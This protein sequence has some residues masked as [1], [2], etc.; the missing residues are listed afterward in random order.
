MHVHWWLWNCTENVV[1]NM[2][3][4]ILEKKCYH[5]TGHK[6][7]LSKTKRSFWYKNLSE[8]SP[9]ILS[10]SQINRPHLIRPLPLPSP[11]PKKINDLPATSRLEISL[12]QGNLILCRGSF[13]GVG[14]RNYYRKIGYELEGPYMV[15]NLWS[16]S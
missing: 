1:E 10:S 6:L 8:L 7:K 15:K 14:T 3:V 2:R 5:N 4:D 11:P 12:N 13:T 9:K 16:T